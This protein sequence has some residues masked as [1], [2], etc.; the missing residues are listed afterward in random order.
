MRGYRL[1]F[2]DLETHRRTGDFWRKEF[3]GDYLP[4]VYLGERGEI[5]EF[6]LAE[7]D[8]ALRSGNY[9][10]AFALFQK[11]FD[12]GNLDAGFRL[13]DMYA[14]GMGMRPAPEKAFAL[15]TELAHRGEVGAEHNLGAC[16]EYGVGVPIDY[17]QAAAHYR[18]AASRGYV[19]SLYSLGS[20]YAQNHLTPRDDVTGLSLLLQAMKRS[21]GDDPASRFV[22]EDR[23]GNMKRLLDRMT[24]TD[25]TK[26]KNLAARPGG[27]I[28]PIQ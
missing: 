7:G 18:A 10:T 6:N 9:P 20:L 4:A 27:Q 5:T 21:V 17:V 8:D 23:P 28:A 13:A 14:R 12:L 19:L 22:R 11:Q 26:A 3:A 1:M 16:Y 25:V 24:P 15:L 2:T